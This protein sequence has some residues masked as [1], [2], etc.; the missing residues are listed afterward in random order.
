MCNTARRR[1]KHNIKRRN[2]FATTGTGP[3]DGQIAQTFSSDSSPKRKPCDEGCLSLCLFKLMPFLPSHWAG[4]LINMGNNRTSHQIAALKRSLRT[5]S[6]FG[7]ALDVQL[8][9]LFMAHTQ[10]HTQSMDF[11]RAYQLLKGAEA[12]LATNTPTYTRKP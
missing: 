10:R 1:K 7:C 11:A 8:N 5:S 12:K 9:L 6:R 2:M 4:L 3:Q